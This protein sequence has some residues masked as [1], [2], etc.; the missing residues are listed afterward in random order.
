MSVVNHLSDSA[1]KANVVF[2]LARAR[3]QLEQVWN[4]LTEM[5]ETKKAEI[6][7]ELVD[8]IAILSDE[9]TRGG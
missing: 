9:V 5:G 2:R 6:V 8:D 4:S 1:R 3:M 7:H